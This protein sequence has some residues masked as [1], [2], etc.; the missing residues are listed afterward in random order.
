MSARSKRERAAPLEIAQRDPRVGTVYLIHFDE[1]LGHA[2]HY[3]GWTDDLDRRLDQHQTGRGSRLMAVV[4][5]RGIAWRV[6]KSWENETRVTERKMKNRGGL[7]RQCPICR[8]EVA[9]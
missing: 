8:G 5:E 7:R 1:P 6:A 9:A 4:V 3:M 2:L